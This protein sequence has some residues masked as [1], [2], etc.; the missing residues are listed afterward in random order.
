MCRKSFSPKKSNNFSINN[1]SCIK[2]ALVLRKHKQIQYQIPKPYTNLKIF[3]NSKLC[4][5]ANY[6]NK[7]TMRN[8]TICFHVFQINKVKCQDLYNSN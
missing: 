3:L 5:L 6:N 8:D 2:I 4:F 7:K 1:K